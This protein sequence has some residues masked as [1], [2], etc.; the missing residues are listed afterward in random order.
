MSCENHSMMERLIEET[1]LIAIS[2]RDKAMGAASDIKWMLVI[3][4]FV[5]GLSSWAL[6]KS[7]DVLFTAGQVVEQLKAQS[8]QAQKNAE[9][10]DVLNDLMRR[11]ML[12]DHRAT[13]GLIEYP[14]GKD[15]KPQEIIC[16]TYTTESG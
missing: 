11:H 15:K 13:I 3:A 12:G 14:P 1:K 8:E 10:I 9:Q 16:E 6:K 2:A 7:G 4:V 5:V